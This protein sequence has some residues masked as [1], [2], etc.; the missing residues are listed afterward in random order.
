MCVREI[1]IERKTLKQAGGYETEVQ[2]CSLSASRL[3]AQLLSSPQSQ[4][5]TLSAAHFLPHFVTY[6]DRNMCAHAYIKSETVSERHSHAR[7]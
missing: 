5:N 3:T 1:E 7:T 6:M 2:A 4:T